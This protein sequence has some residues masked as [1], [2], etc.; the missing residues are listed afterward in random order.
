MIFRTKYS[1]FHT[2]RHHNRVVS[3]INITPFVDVM[4]VLLIVFMISAP[5]LVSGIN[6]NL[7]K[8]DAAPVVDSQDP[9]IISVTQDGKIFYDKKEIDFSA[10]K[11]FIKEN[12]LS[13]NNKIYIRGD[14][15]ISYGDVMNIITEINRAGYHKVS[16]V[17]EN[18]S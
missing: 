8:N 2:R 10:L 11:L 6:V 9:F 16:L 17:T 7:P 4:L 15:N 14:K 12:V 13:Q 18:D 3:D 1:S 5:L